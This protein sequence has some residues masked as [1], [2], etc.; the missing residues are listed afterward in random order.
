[1]N[2]LTIVG[3]L[4]SDPKMHTVDIGGVQT[5][6]VNFWLATDDG[7]KKDKDGNKIGVEFFRV[8]AWRGAAEAIVKY[9]KKGSSMAVAGAVHLDSFPDKTTGALRFYMGIPRPM[10]FEFVGPSG[11]TQERV[12]NDVPAE[13]PEAP[14]IDNPADEDMPW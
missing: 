11:E 1:M 8:T 4:T 7:Q 12:M 14:V 10:M 2:N 9:R 13:A 3:R 6:V 5:P